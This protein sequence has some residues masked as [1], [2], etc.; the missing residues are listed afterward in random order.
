MNV[1]GGIA[2]VS[3]V[4]DAVR[5][6]AQVFRADASEG[7]R[8]EHET[9]QAALGQLSDEFGHA[10]R[11]WFDAFVDGLNRLPRPF[12]ALGTLGLFVYAMADPA[13]FASRMEGL[14]FVPDQL[15]WLLGAIVGFY[16][17]ARELH[18][19][20]GSRGGPPPTEEATVIAGW[21]HSDDAPSDASGN[22]ALDAW[23]RE[24]AA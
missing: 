4:G 17:G 5:G 12:L 9:Q 6:V 19:H 13:G 11:T 2:A 1:A 8:L 16:F 21:H 23:R 15:W 18:Y 3:R 22:A 7:Q 10:K 14:S 20:R 24:R